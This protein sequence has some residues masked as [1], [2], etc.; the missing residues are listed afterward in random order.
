MRLENLADVHPSRHTVGVEDDVHRGAVGEERH[1]LGRQDLADHALVAVP[2]GELVAVGDLALLGDVDADQFVDAGGQ[3]V[4]VLAGEHP[5]SDDLAGLAVRHL[6]RGVADLAGLLT[7]DRPQQPLL[8]GQLGL[9]L[10]GDLADQDV[11]VA[12]LR[13]DAHDAA[14][15]EICQHLIGDVR[16]IPG[17]LLGAQLGVAGVDLVLLDV[18]RGE[19]VLLNQ[20]AGED[21]R[22]LVVVPLPRHD[23][24]EQVLAE[25]H[26]T[27]LGAGAVGNH[28]AGLHPLTGVH[29]RTLVGAGAVIGP[30]ELAHRVAVPGAVVSHNGDVVSRNLFH[31]T[32]FR[33]NNDIAGVDRG[34]QFHTGAHQWRLAAHQRNRLALHVGAHQGTVGVV[35]LEERDHRGGHRDH[36]ARRD[37]HEVHLGG[38]DVL[39]LAALAA[40][41][42]AG[43][44][45]LALRVGRRVGLRHDVA[46]LLVGGQVVDLVGDD[47]TDDLAVR[48]LDETE[49]VDPGVHRQRTDQ[50]DVGALGGLDRTHPAVVAGVHVADLEAGAL[51]GQTT[52]AQRRQAT[53]VGQARQRVVLVHEL[54]QLAGAEELLD[55][56]H[57][58]TDVD[59]GL[60]RDRLNVLGGH[61]LPDDPLHA[62]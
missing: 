22:V 7:E 45:E 14:L 41:Q 1:V 26:L 2:A 28:L 30:V 15:V 5:D 46:V 3:L 4:V 51:T 43:L 44:G 6:Q 39:D 12:D 59:Q 23:R 56:R 60:R 55:G 34:T 32:G 50:T 54:A 13:A 21:D 16:D 24:H 58:G 38:R 53:L 33:G 36:L 40:H 62:G 49:R 47:T 37:V 48:R 61:P 9:A 29:D 10:R 17:D 18:N 31:H 20:P 11:T 8:R 25:G 27:V 35:V 57:D 19:H 52:G 42:H